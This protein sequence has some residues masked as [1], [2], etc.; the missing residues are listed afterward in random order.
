M[1]V[2][3]GASIVHYLI[4]A[5][6]MDHIQSLS[7]R[8]TVWSKDLSQQ[9]HLQMTTFTLIKFIFAHVVQY[10]RTNQIH[11]GTAIALSKNRI[12][13]WYKRFSPDGNNKHTINIQFDPTNLL[14]LL[15]ELSMLPPVT[16]NFCTNPLQSKLFLWV[17]I[18][19]PENSSSS[20]FKTVHQKF[21]A[22]G[23]PTQKSVK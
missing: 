21:E 7:E 22:W 17:K 12:K 13:N 4:N 11:S 23:K 3:V 9:I 18:N 5:G 14:H 20:K 16:V 2:S 19:F 15:P 6:I 10:I 8:R 1:C